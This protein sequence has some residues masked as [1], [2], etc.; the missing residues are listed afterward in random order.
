MYV[1]IYLFILERGEGKEKEMQRNFKVQENHW[2]F[3]SHTPPTRDLADNPGMCP[4]WEWNWTSDFSISRMIPNPLS[5]TS[6]G[7]IT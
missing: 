7:Q 5:H 4:D 1:C 6:Q 3:A 2:S